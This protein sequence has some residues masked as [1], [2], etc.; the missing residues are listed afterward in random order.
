M[1]QSQLEKHFLNLAGEFAV[2]AELF[3]RNVHANITYGNHK[4]TDII[5]IDNDKRVLT[6]EVK[7]SM[8]NRFVTGFFQ[9]FPEE[10][11]KHPDF[12][13]FVHINKDTLKS[14]FYVL[15]HFE[16]AKI[17]MQ[18]NNMSEWT[19]VIGVDNVDIQ[20]LTEYQDNWE[21]VLS[22]VLKTSY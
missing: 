6:I 14:D 3:K 18:K 22:N 19:K 8:S 13:V 4:A 10:K 11:T 16:L 21:S 17:Q 2:C 5:V 20:N 9:K 15:T 7:T 1:K 12:W